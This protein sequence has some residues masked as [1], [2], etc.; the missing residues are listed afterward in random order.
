MMPFA[1][2][3]HEPLLRVRNL[4]KHYVDMHGATIRAV[5]D[6]SFDLACGEVIGV[7]GESGCGKTTLGRTLM[8][9]IPPT[10]GQILVDGEDF[11]AKR[12]AA[13]KAARRNI[14]MVFQDPF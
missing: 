6:V 7:V 5:D 13:L 11:L 12:G 2:A 10:S 1:P 4:A 3:A 9:L 8:R 14:Q